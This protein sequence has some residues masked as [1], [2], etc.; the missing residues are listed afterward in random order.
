MI[1]KNM[2][3]LINTEEN[4]QKLI[5]AGLKD[6]AVK[7]KISLFEKI[8]QHLEKMELSGKAADVHVFFVP[9]R[10][11]VLG[12]HTDYAGGRSLVAVAD[13]EI[14]RASCRERV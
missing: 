3:K 2:H 5:D 6:Q 4:K 8:D 10:I 13:K 11:E 14:G 9:G 7:E 1:G 12:K